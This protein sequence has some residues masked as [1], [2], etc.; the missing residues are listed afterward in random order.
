VV[1][2][3]TEAA[4]TFEL[5]ISQ[6]HPDKKKKF[7]KYYLNYSLGMRALYE[8]RIILNLELFLKL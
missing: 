1:I 4:K 5:G 7:I 8:V 2:R 3:F 6:L